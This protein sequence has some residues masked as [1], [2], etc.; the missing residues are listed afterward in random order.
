MKK[1]SL[2]SL[3]AS[4]LSALMLAATS[5]GTKPVEYDVLI[6]GG[7]ASGVAA[8][9][10][11]ARMD[12]TA[13]IVEETPWLGGMLTS[14]GVS[15][16]DGNFNMPAGFFGEFR[17]SLASHYGSLE[18]LHTGWVSRVLFE[19]SVGDSIFKT[20]TAAEPNLTVQLNSKVS[21]I[22]RING[23]WT[24]TVT[25][26]D[27]NTTQVR[28]QI[29]ID[30]TEL[31]DVAKAVGL[32]YDL[33]MEKREDTH[34]DIAP[35]SA[36]NIVQDLTLV[37]I[38]KDYG[39]D[40]TM[41][42]PEGYERDM[43]ACSCF[44]PLCNDPDEVQRMRDP[45]TMITYGKL[46]NNKYMIN[47]PLHGNDYY[48]NLI[49]MTPAQRDSALMEAR[50]HTLQFVYFL[51]TEVGFSNL[52]LADDEFPTAD[53]LAL[54]PYHRESRRIH[55][56]V[57]FDLN[58][59]STPYDTEL[60]L[61][62][63]GIAVGDYPVDHHHKAYSGADS[64]PNLYF[65]AVPSYN[66]PM[67]VLIP[68]TLNML[69]T[70]KSISV[71]NIANG[72]TRLQPVV[73]QIGQAAGTIAALAVKNNVTVANVDVRDVQN[74]ILADGGY[75]MPYLDVDKFDNRFK[76]YQRIGATGILRGEGKNVD[77]TNETWL[78]HN[79]T[80][81][82]S[83]LADFASFYD[84]EL[85]QSNGDTAV[86]VAQAT[87][88]IA[89]AKGSDVDINPVLN[90]YNIDELQNDDIITRGTWALIIDEILD[91]FNT[92]KVDIKGNFIKQTQKE[93]E[94]K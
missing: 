50:E 64:L 20:I 89:K 29:L 14:A 85:P 18:A 47:W 60:P 41:E 16:V 79:D 6:V 54:I 66:L 8:G 73:V 34:E 35:D 88:L 39:K 21:N 93:D 53:G 2:K 48:L 65:H 19:P 61:Y 69:V 4:A 28:A 22:K 49:E 75:I 32:E 67:G 78:R 92:R 36:N 1:L 11:A 63:T 71:S 37:A 57:R 82:P 31:G 80:L 26:A 15:A 24:A 44:N 68:D 86:T 42:K 56:K 38:L 17:D 46:P 87:E 43:F 23:Y 81:K 7:G 90:K 25:D 33:G 91:P 74:A 55:G 12:V 51:Q 10:Q 9:V 70:E 58:H 76:A 30:G 72:T 77:W 5:C 62:R 84:I 94:E 13:L 40:V 83:E 45:A 52:G 27:G 3:A 59:I